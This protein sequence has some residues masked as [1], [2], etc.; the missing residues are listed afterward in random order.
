MNKLHTQIEVGLNGLKWAGIILAGWL[1]S[2]FGL[3]FVE[4][5]LLD[6]IWIPFAVWLR[7]FLNVGLFIT[8]H[9]AMHGTLYPQ[10]LRVNHGIGAMNVGLY[11][12]FSY[13][14]LL[15]EHHKHHRLSGTLEDPDFADD[16]NHGFVRWFVSFMMRYCSLAQMF[17]LTVIY[18][19]LLA[20]AVD[21]MNVWVFWALPSILSALQ[22]FYFGTYRPHRIEEI[23]FED[24]HRTRSMDAGFLYSFLTCYH[25][26][27]HLEHHRYP[28]VP[29]WAL[30]TVRRAEAGADLGRPSYV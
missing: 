19:G 2:L 4:L 26:G 17:W 5:T 11:A 25:F 13:K 29:W 8:A 6:L 15:L 22:L 28:W 1:V 27:Y 9:D 3:M 12:G 16:Y 14:H 23:A 30:P 20:I 18:L 21:P 10:S 24:E 7:S